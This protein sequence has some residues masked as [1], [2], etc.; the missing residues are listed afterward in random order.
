MSAINVI[1]LGAGVQSSTMA[2]LAAHGEI[3][4]MPIAAVFAD[5]QGEPQ[6]VYNWLDW[7]EPQLPF[8]VIR[9]S[10]GNLAEEALTMR[11]SKEGKMYT[12]S[13]V[14]AFIK[15]PDGTGGIMQRTCTYDF[16]VMM[17]IS[18]SKK[19]AKQHSSSQ[20]IQWIG[21]SLDE[22]HRMKPSREKLIEH[23]YPLIDLRKNRHDCLR[24]M[25]ANGYAK[26]PK[27]AC[28]YCP[29]HSDREWRRLKI[30]EPEEFQKAVDFDKDYRAIKAQTDNIRGIPYLHSSMQPLDEV[31]FSNDE[32]NGQQ[33]LFGN[34]CEGLC[35]V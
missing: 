23:R 4:P 10:K 22:A 16:K 3:E 17:L 21:I 13:L 24:W 12:R 35:G 20:V 6:S 7:L 25:E 31:D 28:V 30:E 18:A 14:P 5:T 34:E 29:Y 26:P 15:N 8:P 1:S 27:S 11:T 19:L 9:V 33:V 2:L 32:D